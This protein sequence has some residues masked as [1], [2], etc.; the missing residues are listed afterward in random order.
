MTLSVSI[1]VQNSIFLVKF[2]SEVKENQ[3][4]CE[5]KNIIY[6]G[7][8]IKVVGIFLGGR[9]SSNFDIGQYGGLRVKIF[10][11]PTSFLGGVI[12]S[13]IYFDMGEGGVKKLGQ[14]SDL[15]YGRTLI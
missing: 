10:K 9:G 7:A 5:N 13:T 2:S 14:N 12:E 15:F 11:I 8:S 3:A 6:K 1:A 4:W